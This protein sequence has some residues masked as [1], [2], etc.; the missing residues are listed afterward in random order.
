MRWT[1]LAAT[2]GGVNESAGTCTC[3]GI[4]E[5]DRIRM[6]DE[7]MRST[8]AALQAPAGAEWLALAWIVGI[9]CLVGA[10][11]FFSVRRYLRRNR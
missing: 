5:V 9:L 1:S 2:S 4:I 6:Y 7:G 8:I 10:V 3:S 11:A